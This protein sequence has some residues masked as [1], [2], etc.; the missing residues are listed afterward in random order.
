MT[1]WCTFFSRL[2]TRPITHLKLMKKSFLL[3]Q[4]LLVILVLVPQSY[5]QQDGAI[6]KEILAFRN[7]ETIRSAGTHIASMQLAEPVCL[8][9]ADD[10][11]KKGFVEPP[12]AF[13]RSQN[14]R[15]DCSLIEVTYNGFTPEAQAAFQ[16]A[17]DI[18]ESLISSPVTIRIN[19]NF[20]PL[21]PGVLGSAGP[22]F[23]YRDFPGAVPGTW[24]GEALADKISGMDLSGP[25]TPDINS[26][27]SSNFAWYFGRDGQAPPGTYDF[28]T[29]VLHELGHGLGFFGSANAIPAPVLG[30][31]GFGA[32]AFGTIYDRFTE[33]GDGTT[34]TSVAP[35]GVVS[36]ALGA[37][38]Q[39]GDLFINGPQANTGNGGIRPLIYAPFPFQ[40]GSSYSHFDEATFPAGTPHS[41]M[42]PF[43]SFQE[44][45]H[46]PGSAC[47]GMFEDHGWMQTNDCPSVSSIDD[48]QPCVITDILQDPNFPAGVCWEQFIDPTITLPGTHVNCFRIDGINPFNQPLDASQYDVKVE[49][50]SLPILALSYDTDGMGQ[51][52]FFVCVGNIPTLCCNQAMDVSISL[53]SGCTFHAS[54]V[55]IAPT[56]MVADDDVPPIVTAPPDIR[57][58][59]EES[60]QPDHTGY[61][62]A[63]DACRVTFTFND[64]TISTGEDG[65]IV[66][67][68]W[69][70]TDHCGNSSDDVQLIHI[71]NRV[72]L[73]ECYSV[74]L[75]DVSTDGTN[76][77][78][79][80]KV[81]ADGLCR[82]NLRS[83]S[84][85]IPCG[86][87]ALLPEEGTTYQGN[88]GASFVVFNPKG[89]TKENGDGTVECET[90]YSLTFGCSVQGFESGE[91][92]Y[93]TYTLPGDYTEKG[94]PLYGFNPKVEIRSGQLARLS[95]RFIVDNCCCDVT[96][97]KVR[98]PIQSSVSLDNLLQSNDQLDITVFP[99][100]AKSHI[101]LAISSS[102]E[103]ILD[104]QL[105]DLL[106]RVVLTRSG[107][108][109]ENDYFNWKLPESLQNGIYYIKIRGKESKVI[110]IAISK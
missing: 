25:G 91:V 93:F 1:L 88:S 17:V 84:F 42:T 37:L 2:Q 16:H 10:E 31:Y 39:G 66:E 65:T 69:T 68:T 38:F 64:M 57:I 82:K 44:S 87:Q 70:G 8:L 99:N 7:S 74:K 52:Y 36:P 12:A 28:V 107:V 30:V 48:R 110:P 53:G 81:Y 97:P 24:Y 80:W 26:N 23:I 51:Q 33:R 104:I 41:M 106:G 15:D 54:D 56:C 9:Y 21:G 45:V 85:E 89:K 67:R 40:G 47:L 6:P 27:F 46:D 105:L 101:N 55:Y 96:L 43:L 103:E 22:V 90:F 98:L 63:V 32:P 3:L 75:L 92:E 109:R 58:R 13:R 79:N 50:V 59:C 100:P 77:T 86:S 83:I 78:F 61:P 18:W 95:P 34:T 60:D 71:D 19:A 76:T 20:V 5:A 94:D 35:A 14:Q 72:P 73:D 62:T 11:I 29:V 102:T 108:F 4:F 49:G